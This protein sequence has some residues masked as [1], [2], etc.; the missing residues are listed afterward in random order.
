[1]NLLTSAT[2]AIICFAVLG[3]LIYRDVKKKRK[4]DK[5]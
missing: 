2:L 4:K 1:M 3:Y 5:E